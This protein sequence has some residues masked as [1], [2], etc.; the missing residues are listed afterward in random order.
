MLVRPQQ[1]SPTSFTLTW[2]PPSQEVR[3]G[4]IQQ[5]TIWITEL[6]TGRSITLTSASTTV[7]VTSLHPYYTYNC[8][9]AAETSAI[10]PFSSPV[11]IQLPESR[12]YNITWNR[13]GVFTLISSQFSQL[14]LVLHLM[15]QPDKSLPLV[16][17]CHGQLHLQK[18]IMVS[19]V[20]TL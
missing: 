8:S 3:N 11:V 20:T 19:Y 4:I 7:N 6:E 15:F 12:K 9:V 10:G 18:I 14:L 16:S 1:I 2:D 17:H 13:L 5:Y